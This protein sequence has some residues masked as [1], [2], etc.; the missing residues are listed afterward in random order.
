MAYCLNTRNYFTKDWENLPRGG[1]AKLIISESQTPVYAKARPLPYAIKEKVEDEL[2][3]MVKQLLRLFH[4]VI[5]LRPL[6]PYRK[7][8]VVFEFVE[9]SKLR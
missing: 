9:I 4:I 3:N 8:A 5:G 6:C 1:E 2:S 7:L